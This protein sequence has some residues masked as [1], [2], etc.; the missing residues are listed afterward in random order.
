MPVLIFGVVSF[1]AGVLAFFLPET[2]GKKLPDTVKEAEL[3]GVE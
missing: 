2:K 3:V 1:V